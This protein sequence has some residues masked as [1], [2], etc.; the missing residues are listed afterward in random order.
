VVIVVVVAVEVVVVPGTA[1]AMGNVVVAG[2]RVGAV[3]ARRGCRGVV[4][5]VR[6]ACRAAGGVLVVV[7]N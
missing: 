3:D 4:V 2:R 6:G 5:V 7:L 1:S